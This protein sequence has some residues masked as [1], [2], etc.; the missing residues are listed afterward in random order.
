MLRGA[1]KRA[2]KEAT[3]RRQ[4]DEQSLLSPAPPARCTAACRIPGEQYRSCVERGAIETT[5]LPVK[6]VLEGRLSFSLGRG[7]LMSRCC[8]HVVYCVC[9]AQELAAAREEIALLKAALA[10]KVSCDD[11]SPQQA[12]N[13]R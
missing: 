13:T 9:H 2:R 4:S 11:L 1:C 7:E 5:L 10:E 6:T 8:Y 3:S 12:T